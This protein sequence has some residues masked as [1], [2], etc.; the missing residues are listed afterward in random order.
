MIQGQHN[1]DHLLPALYVLAVLLVH[2]LPVLPLA[3]PGAVH[4]YLALST[5]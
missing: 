3:L 1:V 5:L 2:I 4:N